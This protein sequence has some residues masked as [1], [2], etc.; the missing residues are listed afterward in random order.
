MVRWS[1][2]TRRRNGE[3]CGSEVERRQE[4]EYAT[5]GVKRVSGEG[6]T[7]GKTVDD[8]RVRGR[9]SSK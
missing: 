4:A 5:K 8:R 7:G 1:T 3:D 6:M 9:V 2:T